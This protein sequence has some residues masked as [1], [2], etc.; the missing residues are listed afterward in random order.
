[1]DSRKTTERA[2][3]FMSRLKRTIPSTL[4]LLCTALILS[5]VWIVRGYYYYANF[6]EWLS[7]TIPI[8]EFLVA[9]H[10]AVGLL[11]DVIRALVRRVRGDRNAQTPPQARSALE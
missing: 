3:R 11:F 5:A 6:D 8:V 7:H 10:V 9:V 1:M 4:F 2:R